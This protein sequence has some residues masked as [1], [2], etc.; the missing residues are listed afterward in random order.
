MNTVTGRIE[1]IESAPGRGRAQGKIAFSLVVG[2]ESF[3]LGFRPPVG[4]RIG[5]TVT[6]RCEIKDG[7]WKSAYD[8]RV[9]DGPAPVPAPSS[10]IEPTRTPVSAPVSTPASVPPVTGSAVDQ[11]QLVAAVLVAA[12]SIVN[13][14]GWTIEDLVSMVGSVSKKLE[15]ATP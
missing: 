5:D 6:F 12:F 13:R 10:P 8:V 1:S 7:K 9:V 15:K 14:P 11:S 2:G 4:L 3:G